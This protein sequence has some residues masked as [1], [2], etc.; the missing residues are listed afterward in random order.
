MCEYQSSNIC[1]CIVT[2]LCRLALFIPKSTSDIPRAYLYWYFYFRWK[3][4]KCSIIYTANRV[5]CRR[6]AP[7][8]NNSKLKTLFMTIYKTYVTLIVTRKNLIFKWNW[9]HTLLNICEWLLGSVSLHWFVFLNCILNKY[10]QML[11]YLNNLC[12]VEPV[13]KDYPWCNLKVVF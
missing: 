1:T 13:F 2:T 9:L 10:M 5:T 6:A 11:L 12:T 4:E 3:V 8:R 7:V